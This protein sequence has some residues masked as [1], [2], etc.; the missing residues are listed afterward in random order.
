MAGGAVRCWWGGGGVGGVSGEQQ[1]QQ[2]KSGGLKRWDLQPPNGRNS[3]P[4]G[5]VQMQQVHQLEQTCF[6]SAVAGAAG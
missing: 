2:A 3:S 1:V 5:G 4:G 6:A